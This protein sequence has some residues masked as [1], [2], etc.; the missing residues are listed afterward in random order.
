MSRLRCWYRKSIRTGIELGGIRLPEFA[1][2]L[3]TYTPWNLRDPSIGA[4]HQRVAFEGSFLPFARDQ[5]ARARVGDPR[6]SIA[7][8]YSDKADYLQRYTRALDALIRERYL[9]PEDRDALL[10]AGSDEW[11]YAA[12]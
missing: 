11:D 10:Q 5:A 2:P 7:E 3:A 8:R 12:R 6:A 9:L 4:A 1:A